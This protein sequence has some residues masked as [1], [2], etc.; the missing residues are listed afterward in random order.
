MTCQNRSYIHHEKLREIDRERETHSKMESFLS[1]I[2]HRSAQKKKERITNMPCEESHE[3]SSETTEFSVEILP[4]FRS[5]RVQHR[6]F[7]ILK[8]KSEADHV[9]I[10]ISE[11]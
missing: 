4:S 11:Y 7:F 2:T 1:E 8:I 3:I 5:A 6:F 10:A 9:Q